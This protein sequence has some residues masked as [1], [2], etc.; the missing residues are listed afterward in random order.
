VGRRTDT[1]KIKTELRLTQTQLE[2]ISG[3]EQLGIYGDNTGE[4]VRRL[5]D[6]GIERIAKD[7][8]IQKTISARDALAKV[9]RENIKRI[10]KMSSAG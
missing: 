7:E 6:E 9:K 2:F 4:I 10:N 8:L 3:L 5:I 1:P